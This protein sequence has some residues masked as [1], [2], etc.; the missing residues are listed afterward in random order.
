M[1]KIIVID[2]QMLVAQDLAEAL[3]DLLAGV[4][5]VTVQP[6]NLEPTTGA[7]YDTAFV[8][9]NVWRSEWGSLAPEVVVYGTFGETPSPAHVGRTLPW[10]VTADALHALISEMAAAP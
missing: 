9:S 5:V 10:P 4:T 2:T 6:D 3:Q 1:Q 7:P 8:A